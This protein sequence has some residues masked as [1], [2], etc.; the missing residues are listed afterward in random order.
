MKSLTVMLGVV[1]A[2][3][4]LTADARAAE[5]AAP[6]IQLAILLDTSNSMDGLIDQARTQLWSIVNTFIAAKRDGR[7]PR[8]EVALYE[9]GN[10]S[11][12]SEVGYSRQLLPFT[13][14][15][16]RVS[17]VL[18]ALKTNG[19]DE[20]CGA[21]IER[22]TKEL[23]WSEGQGALRVVYIAGNEPFTQ[24]SVDYTLACKAAVSR[25][26]IVNTI[27]C[28]SHDDGVD[29]KWKDGAVLADG[30][31]VS[32]DQ[33]Q[34]VA[35]IEAP[36]D[37]EIARL[38]AELNTTYIAFGSD[39]RRGSSNQSAQDSNAENVGRFA[40]TSR[41]VTKASSN[42]S[43][44][45]WD[46]VDAQKEATVKI[47]DVKVEDL[48][49]NMRRMTVAERKAYVQAKAEERARIQK[50]IAE[51]GAARDQYVAQERKKQA[52]AG[53]ETLDSAI[54]KT[55]REQALGHGFRFE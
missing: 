52:A 21:V 16:D 55:V 38:G 40:M 34:K 53:A 54:I 2:V 39:G 51:L 46:M 4:G 33:N 23:A 32:I 27:H 45:G 20:Y 6:E 24:G 22:A 47:E 49:E 43:N 18:F 29:G 28:G 48:P 30:R 9:Y 31:Y 15:L 8:L 1:I 7:R 25:G 42:Y 26:I 44:S 5:K 17:E 12:P 35:A 3:V 13:T 11:I 10:N 14:D 36:Q 19:G 41:V 37:G 50:R